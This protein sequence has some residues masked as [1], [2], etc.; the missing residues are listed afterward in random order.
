MIEATK[1]SPKIFHLYRILKFHYL[2]KRGSKRHLKQLQLSKCVLNLI[3][4]YV[5]VRL[6]QLLRLNQ[7]TLPQNTLLSPQVMIYRKTHCLPTNTLYQTTEYQLPSLR[8]HGGIHS[9]NLQLKP[10]FSINRSTLSR[11]APNIQQQLGD[12]FVHRHCSLY[13]IIRAFYIFDLNK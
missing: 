11:T 6:V 5:K 10:K 7:K 2:R 1:A 3:L 13:L 4:H 9:F 12:H 8:P